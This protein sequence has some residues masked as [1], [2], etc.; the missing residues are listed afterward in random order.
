MSKYGSRG[1]FVG[2]AFVFCFLPLP[3]KPFPS[4]RQ[5]SVPPNTG[6]IDE[7]D[8]CTGCSSL[9]LA[10]CCGDTGEADGVVGADGGVGFAECPGS[11]SGSTSVGFSSSPL[12]AAGGADEDEAVE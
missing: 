9:S 1:L 4:F 12:A 3:A 8:G 10:G 5:V 7:D 6:G 2:V 11:F